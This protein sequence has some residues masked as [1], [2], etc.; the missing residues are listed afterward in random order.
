RQPSDRRSPRPGPSPPPGW[1]RP[2]SRSPKGA[3]PRSRKRLPLGV[4]GLA[5]LGLAGMLLMA[6]TRRHK[7]GQ[8]TPA[9]AQAGCH[10]PGTPPPP[11]PAPPAPSRAKPGPAKILARTAEAPNH[12]ARVKEIFQAHCLEC[13]GGKK[14]KA[15]V[16][17]LDREL[18]VKN[19]KVIPEKPDD[20]ELF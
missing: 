8:T 13:H 3:H 4:I 10:P 15:K 2:R 18:L 20:S 14:T 5:V 1:D 17:I 7:K 6:R 11:P 9:L 16:K 12:A 19:E